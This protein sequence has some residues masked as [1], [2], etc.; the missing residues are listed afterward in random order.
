MLRQPLV[1]LRDAQLELN[2]LIGLRSHFQRSLIK[3]ERLGEVW[4]LVELG[5]CE[6]GFRNLEVDVRDLLL[7]VERQQ[8]VGFILASVARLIRW[9]VLGRYG[10][11]S[12][13]MSD[14]RKTVSMSAYWKPIT[15]ERK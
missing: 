2:L 9:R 15:S 10:T 4:L 14:R 3:L 6:V 7:A 12:D 11:W 8:A 5:R 13:R 1:A